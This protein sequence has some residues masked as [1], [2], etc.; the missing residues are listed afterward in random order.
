MAIRFPFGLTRVHWLVAQWKG[1]RKERGGYSMG[2]P[3]RAKPIS[4]P[5]PGGWRQQEGV[6]SGTIGRFNLN[7]KQA[8]ERAD[9]SKPTTHLLLSVQFPGLGQEKQK[10]NM[11]AGAVGVTWQHRRTGHGISHRHPG[12]LFS[13]TAVPRLLQGAHYSAESPAGVASVRA[14]A[15]VSN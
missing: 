9:I 2:M 6:R 8:S 15:V 3:D 4:Q 12:G 5:Y 14:R 7:S 13:K 11:P 1:D 10:S